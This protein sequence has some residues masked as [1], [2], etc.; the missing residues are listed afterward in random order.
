MAKDAIRLYIDALIADG[1]PV[2]E[3]SKHPQAIVIDVAA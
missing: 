1:M 3:E 2:P